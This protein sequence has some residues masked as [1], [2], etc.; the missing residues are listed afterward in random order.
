[1]TAPLMILAVLS[2]FGGNL[3]LLHWLSPLFHAGHVEVPDLIRWLPTVAGRSRN[4]PGLFYVRSQYEAVAKMNEAPVWTDASLLWNKW[5]VDEI[6]D[7]T[8]CP[9]HG[10]ASGLVLESRRYPR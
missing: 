3:P 1:M 10:A 5:Y 8:D 4:C 9:I 7:A 6:Y 2:I